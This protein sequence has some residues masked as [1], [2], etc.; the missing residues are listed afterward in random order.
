MRNVTAYHFSISVPS[1]ICLCIMLAYFTQF[2]QVTL[3]DA[4]EA[5]I[6]PYSI[7]LTWWS[8][9]IHVHVIR[10]IF[11]F[12][13]DSCLAAA[14][15]WTTRQGAMREK[16]TV[17]VPCAITARCWTIHSLKFHG[18]GCCNSCFVLLNCSS[19]LQHTQFVTVSYGT[20]RCTIKS[21]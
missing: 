21:N 4:F 14:S 3:S 15:H 5:G 11:I 6:S 20:P 7:A 8:L 17:D 19:I 9:G 1:H 2:Q 12:L 13:W 16:W 18:S 10:C